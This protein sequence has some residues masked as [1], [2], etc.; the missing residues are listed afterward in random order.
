MAGRAELRERWTPQR[1]ADAKEALE[2]WKKPKRLEQVAFG[3]HEGRLDL[4]GLSIHTNVGG[5]ATQHVA[6]G[7]VKRDYTMV[8]LEKPPEFHNVKWESI[9]FSYAEIDHLR[10][11]LSEVRDC[12]FISGGF[13]DWRNWG[14]RY[15][16][17][18]FSQ[19][20]LQNSN[21]G[22]AAYKGRAVEYLNCHW[23]KGNLKSTNLSNGRYR[24]CR[25]EDIRLTDQ[26]IQNSS[27]IGCSFSGRLPDVTFDGRDLDTERPWGV[28]PDSLVD[29][30]FSEC[31]LEDTA[32]LGVDMRT[33]RLPQGQGQ[34]IARYPLVARGAY[35]W[36]NNANLS[37]NETRWLQMYW[38]G[39]VTQLPDDAEG[40]INLKGFGKE[41]LELIEA[42]MAATP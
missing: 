35:E 33:I 11:F 27:F 5:V 30:D 41:A 20:N 23:R 12:L 42:S 25:F 15:S 31:D 26:L 21:I 28:R 24:G 1:A 34:R 9:D 8:T 37:S 39:H 13:R 38:Q 10:L 19:A 4:R 7:G 40:W 22:G 17:C 29:C 2:N 32:F 3:Q 36:A 18:D 16:D 14:V 6:A